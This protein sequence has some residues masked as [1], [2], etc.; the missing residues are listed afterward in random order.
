MS[1]NVYDRDTAEHMAITV[2]KTP[3]GEPPEIVTTGV[4]FA[5]HAFGQPRTAWEAP[6]VLEGRLGVWVEDYAPGSWLVDARVTDS[7]EIPVFNVARFTVV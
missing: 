2:T 6:F 7:P 4:E 5:V 1:I 3:F